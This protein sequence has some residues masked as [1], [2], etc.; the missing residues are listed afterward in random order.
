MA[1]GKK[2]AIGGKVITIERIAEKS[3]K[4][5]R[6]QLIQAKAQVSEET[7]KRIFARLH[8]GETEEIKAA[9][10]EAQDKAAELKAAAEAKF[11]K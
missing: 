6:Q 9:K 7:A 2:L 4:Q 3:Y 5:F 11:N 1:Q 10:A 8:D